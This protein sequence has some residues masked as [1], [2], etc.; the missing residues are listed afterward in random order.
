MFWPHNQ[1]QQTVLPSTLLAALALSLLSLLLAAAPAQAD[2]AQPGLKVC[3]LRWGM[4]HDLGYCGHVVGQDQELRRV[5]LGQVFVSHF[6]FGWR[7]ACSG[8]QHLG[9][10]ETGE[11]ITVHKDCLDRKPGLLSNWRD[12]AGLLQGVAGVALLLLGA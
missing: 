4:N 8:W 1:S 9:Q 5:K 6:G 7:N 2:Q 10:L 12:T 3:A 11:I